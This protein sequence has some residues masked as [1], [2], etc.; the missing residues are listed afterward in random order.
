MTRRLLVFV[1]LLSLS[2]TGCLWVRRD[3]GLTTIHLQGEEAASYEL[4]FRGEKTTYLVDLGS[5]TS[6]TLPLERGLWQM[7]AFA[8]NT[9]GQITAQSQGVQ[10]Q[11]GRQTILSPT[12]W[13]TDQVTTD[14]RCK[15]VSHIWNLKGQIELS[16]EPLEVQTGTIEVWKRPRSSPFWQRLQVLPAEAASF[17]DD[18]LEARDYLYALRYRP[19]TPEVLASPLVLSQ[20]SNLGVLEVTWD[21]AHIYP[22]LSTLLAPMSFPREQEREEVFTDLIAHFHTESAY[23]ERETLLQ[24]LGLIPLREIPAILAVVVKPGEG[25]EKT[26]FEWSSYQDQNLYLEPNGIVL[27][28]SLGTRGS[29]SW[30]L[31]YIRVPLAQQITTGDR[32]VRIAV[33]DSGL[34][35]EHLPSGVEVLPGY[36]FVRKNSDTKDDYAPVYHGTDVARTMSQVIPQV[37][38]Q[39]VK[40][41][42]GGGSGRTADLV[43]GLLYAA[44]LHDTVYNPHPAQIINLSLGAKGQMPPSDVAKAI[45]RIRRETDILLIA[46]SGNTQGGVWSPGVFYPAALPE[47]LGVG[48]IE[49]GNPP[50][51]AAYSHYGEGLDLVAPPSFKDG[52]SFSTALVSGV[53]GLMLSQ[54]IPPGEVRNV[55][56]TSAMDLGESG[57]DE[58]HGHGLVNAHWAVLG[59]TDFVL[60]IQD[61]SG[62]SVQEKV[63]LKGTKK[64]LV[65]PPG[66]Y[67]VEAWVNLGG[68]A[69]DYISGQSTVTV[70]EDGESLIHLTLR[71]RN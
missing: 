45:E 25:S 66:D 28:A 13:Q 33:L 67:A 26:L 34:N 16:W 53:A 27:A 7:Q 43:E 54:G 19:A 70:I 71:E 30:Y 4:L 40:V 48:A 22:A 56:T 46:A 9:S 35:P 11:G 39:P 42:G 18:D 51:R 1:L 14:V 36:N 24:S 57:W 38:I 29:S 69:K 52:T 6:I 61:A 58:E 62:N 5:S 65:L 15:E 41:L 32:E 49:R 50:Q 68:G 55:L 12:L 37:S 3:N 47:V 20:G 31:E 17:L 10:V 60:T 44:G 8:R 23:E 64:R 59:I 21:F 2:F 63:P